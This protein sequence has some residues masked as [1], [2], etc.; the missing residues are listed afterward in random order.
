MPR[1]SRS[2]RSSNENTYATML[3]G[4]LSTSVS[5]ARTKPSRECKDL[6]TSAFVTECGE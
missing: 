6:C 3:A 4:V 2:S 1:S 5:Q